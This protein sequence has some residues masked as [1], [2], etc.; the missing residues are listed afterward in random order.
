ML[1]LM[2]MLMIC[3]NITAFSYG[4]LNIRECTIQRLYSQRNTSFFSETFVFFLPKQRKENQN[5]VSLLANI[6]TF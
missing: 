5:I 1:M 4:D 2:L 3:R 6:L